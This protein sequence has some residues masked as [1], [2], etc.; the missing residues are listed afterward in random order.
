MIESPLVS[1]DGVIGEPHEWTGEHFGEEAVAY[2]LERLRHTDTMVMGRGTYELFSRIWAAPENEYAAAIY[3]MRKYVFS[4]TLEQAEWNNTEI[5]RT[6]VAGTVHELKQQDG[7]DI[8]LYGHGPV[9]QTLLEAAL[10]SSQVRLGVRVEPAAVALD[11]PPHRKRVRREQEGRQVR[12][13]S[14]ECELAADARPV[15]RDVYGRFGSLGR[16]VPDPAQRE[17]SADSS[18]EQI[19]PVEPAPRHSARVRTREVPGS[20]RCG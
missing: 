13:A 6:D 18:D 9:G 7:K 12:P 20:C 4:S 10:V 2:A 3:D 5:V 15:P 8:V 19:P 1:A 16:G 17:G 14:V 11:R